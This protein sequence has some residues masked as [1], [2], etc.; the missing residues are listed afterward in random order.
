MSQRQPPADAA[1]TAG[2]EATCIDEYRLG[3][4]VEATVRRY[5]GGDIASSSDQ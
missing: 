5:D 3:E 1:R 4:T 2:Y